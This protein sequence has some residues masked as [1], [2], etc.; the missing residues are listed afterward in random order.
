MQVAWFIETEA[1][2]LHKSRP[3]TLQNFGIKAKNALPEDKS[4]TSLLKVS[5]SHETERGD[6]TI[7]LLP[8]AMPEHFTN[9][10]M[11]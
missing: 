4:F 11:L 3:F 9:G 8:E 6:A 1:Y 7:V 2:L 5:Q 10:D